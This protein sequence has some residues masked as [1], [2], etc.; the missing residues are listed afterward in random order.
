MRKPALFPFILAAVTLSAFGQQSTLAPFCESEIASQ[1]ARISE[2]TTEQRKAFGNYK[3]FNADRNSRHNAIQEL[4]RAH[5]ENR[6]TGTKTDNLAAS[7]CLLKVIADSHKDKHIAA[8]AQEGYA[9]RL[10]SGGGV[11]RNKDLAIEY[12]E[13]SARWKYASAATHLGLLYLADAKTPDNR[14]KAIYW[15]EYGAFTAWKGDVIGGWSAGP[16]QPIDILFKLYTDLKRPA[17][18]GEVLERARALGYTEDQ[19]P[20]H[21]T[22]PPG[23]G[24]TGLNNEY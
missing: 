15:L 16:A 24:A 7:A 18:A 1:E 19:L 8:Y 6:T 17:A 21:F 14:Q 4:A 10:L 23:R 20:K 11:S 9:L 2:L 5:L 12:L 3:Y 22:K 13:R